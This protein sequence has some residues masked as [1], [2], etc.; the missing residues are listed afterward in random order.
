[1][2]AQV[3]HCIIY[4]AWFRVGKVVKKKRA[5]GK[6]LADSSDLYLLSFHLYCHDFGRNKKIAED[7]SKTMANKITKHRNWCTINF[8]TSPLVFRVIRANAVQHCIAPRASQPAGRQAGSTGNQRLSQ[9]NTRAGVLM[10]TQSQNEHIFKQS[11]SSCTINVYCICI[12]TQYIVI[13][14]NIIRIYII[15][16]NA[17]SSSSNMRTERSSSSGIQFE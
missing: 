4:T 6:V 12:C 10:G 2:Y 11:F 13:T 5:I 9:H 3:K 14:C 1:M 16:A 17:F 15:N 7:Q 8:S